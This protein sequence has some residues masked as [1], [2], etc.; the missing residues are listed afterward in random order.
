LAPQPNTTLITAL[1]SP[2]APHIAPLNHNQPCCQLLLMHKTHTSSTLNPESTAFNV[3]MNATTKTEQRLP[4]P[5][6]P[7][8][9][10]HSR[11]RQLPGRIET[12]GATH[13]LLDPTA[14][15]TR[16][17][18]CPPTHN[19]SASDLRRSGSEHGHTTRAAHHKEAGCCPSPPRAACF[20][21]CRRARKHAESE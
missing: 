13:Q 4:P 20:V 11:I 1:A 17:T 12:V 5:I 2:T 8:P 18:A 16:R 10:V 6:W 19:T 21:R 9:A 3:T 14:Q 7:S 15:K